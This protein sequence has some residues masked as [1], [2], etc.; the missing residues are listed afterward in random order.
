MIP[1]HLWGEYFGQEIGDKMSVL[2]DSPFFAENG[3]NTAVRPDIA[4]DDTPITYESV[5]ELKGCSA[6]GAIDV[7]RRP[8]VMD[9]MGIEK[10]LL[11]PSFGFAGFTMA[12]SPIFSHDVMG[13]DL[14]VER[15]KEVG[16]EAVAAYNDW[17]IQSLKSVAGPRVRPVALMFTETIESMLS[18]L[19]HLI[20]HGVKAVWLPSRTPP[21]GTSPADPALDEFWKL[22]ADNDVALLLHIGTDFEFVNTFGW[23]ANVPAFVPPVASAEFQVSPFSGSTVHLA[24]EHFLIAM[25]LGGVFD[26]VPNLRFGVAELGAQWLGPLAERLDMWAGVF[27]K[28]MRSTISEKPSA[29]LARNVRVTPFYFEPIDQYYEHYPQLEDCYCYSSDYPHTEGGPESKL[30]FY[31]LLERFDPIIAEKFFV[32]NGSWLVP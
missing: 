18:Q 6:P 31:E 28:T 32:T 12:L 19:Q 8:Q 22:A 24:A 4:G 17:A 9:A 1:I 30:R 27:H 15:T 14:S 21:A 3:T 10:A 7:L 23:M 25:T 16:L 2:G 11:F 5:W 13:I 20:D 29:Y 26:R